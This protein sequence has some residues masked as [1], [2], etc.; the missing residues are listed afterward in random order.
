MILN[1][2]SSFVTYYNERVPNW[3]K[4]WSSHLNEDKNLKRLIQSIGRFIQKNN[5]DVKRLV[6]SVIDHYFEKNKKYPTL[7]YFSGHEAL[8]LY[9]SYQLA[10]NLDLN[11]SQKIIVSVK[12]SMQSVQN[13]QTFNLTYGE[14]VKSL[15]QTGKL[16]FYYSL[17]HGLREDVPEE[18][19]KLWD[20]DDVVKK[21]VLDVI[22]C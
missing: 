14:A 15:H 1:S 16:D 2:T 22:F 5:L 17:A 10:Y 7:F 18:Y 11:E 3:K 13:L 12:K 8:N 6:D 19:L 21:L 9:N 4:I 20:K